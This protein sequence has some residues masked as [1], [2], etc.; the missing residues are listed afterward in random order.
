MYQDICHCH[1]LLTFNL[2]SLISLASFSCVPKRLLFYFSSFMSSFWR[3]LFASTNTSTHFH[4]DSVT[5]FHLLNVKS[6]HVFLTCPHRWIHL[7]FRQ[8]TLCCLLSQRLQLSFVSCASP[9][10]SEF[11]LGLCIKVI[12][13]VI[14]NKDM[15]KIE[16]T[17]TITSLSRPLWRF[18]AS[19]LICLCLHN[20]PN[21]FILGDGFVCQIFILKVYQINWG[22]KTI[23]EKKCD[24]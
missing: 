15:Y 9:F 17:C 2:L 22:M 13:M 18:Y 10:C 6:W 23:V 24:G 14:M 19:E 3:F 4:K 20:F 16:L 21:S 11:Y 5:W 12:T 7:L 8:K 1:I